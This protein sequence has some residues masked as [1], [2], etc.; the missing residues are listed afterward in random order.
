MLGEF[1][2]WEINF[3]AA[4]GSKV[5]NYKFAGGKLGKEEHNF[6]DPERLL[7]IREFDLKLGLSENMA[8]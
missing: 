3:T 4:K 1:L 5:A 7:S 8:T 2:I 6:V